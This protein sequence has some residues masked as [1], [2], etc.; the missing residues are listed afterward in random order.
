M[1]KFPFRVFS[2]F[3]GSNSASH[4]LFKFQ[5]SRFRSLPVLCLLISVLCLPAYA[6][7]FS[8]TYSLST[9]TITVENTQKR[10]SWAPV[11]ILI[12][13]TGSV[14]TTITI[15]RI[16]NGNE[17]LLSTVTLTGVQDVTWIPDADYPFNFGDSLVISTTATGGTLE[18]I[19]RSN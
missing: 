15:K 6:A 2:V 12:H 8:K 18:L 10:S 5:V 3:R 13:Y 11:A 1:S 19:Q 16:N 7:G 17:Y 9:G 4:R 14:D